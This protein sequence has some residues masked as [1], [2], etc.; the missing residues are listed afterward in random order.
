VGA[1]ILIGWLIVDLASVFLFAHLDRMP[2][3]LVYPFVIAGGFGYLIVRGSPLGLLGALFGLLT[4]LLP[5][6]E[7]NAPP[8]NVDTAYG[9]VCG[10]LLG[11]AAA[12]ISQ[13]LLW[14]STAMQIFT[15]RAA[16]QLDLCLRGLAAGAIGSEAAARSQDVADVVSAHAKQLS[17]LGQLHAQAQAEPVERALDDTRRAAL[18]AL[19]QD[20][21]DASLRAPRWGVGK[22][23]AVPSDAAAALTSLR[24]ALTHQDAVLVAS[25]KDAAA[26]LRGSATSPDSRLRE[27]QAAVDAQT[28]ALRGHADLATERD[29]HL[30]VELLAQIAAS[31]ALV[32]SQLQL[33]AWLADWHRAQGTQS[34]AARTTAD[35]RTPRPL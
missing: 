26:A 16:A 15:Q 4:A 18:L 17:L 34:D 5:V 8:G 3:S 14:P 12:L 32:K 28:D 29:T 2:L 30:T 1:G 24:E 21:F 6:F 20:L 10:M 11:L 13:R 9:L 7:G 22:Q 33:E 25:L 27:A 19:G 31:G 23:A 35:A